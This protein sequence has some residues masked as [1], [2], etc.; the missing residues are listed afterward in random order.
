MLYT[1]SRTYLGKE[2]DERRN[3]RKNQNKIVLFYPLYTK[4]LVNFNCLLSY[5]HRTQHVF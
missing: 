1:Y 5:S 3:G 2:R 4:V